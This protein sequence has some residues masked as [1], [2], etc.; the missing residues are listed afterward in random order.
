MDQLYIYNPYITKKRKHDDVIKWIHFPR[1]WPFVRGIHWSPMNSSHKG[2][3]R[4]AWMWSLICAS[5]NGSVNNRE[6]GDLRRHR[7]HYDVTVMKEYGHF[8][9]ACNGNQTTLK[10][11]QCRLLPSYH[12]YSIHVGQFWLQSIFFARPGWKLTMFVG[13]HIHEYM[14]FWCPIFP[15]FD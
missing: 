12:K 7:A 4:W 1:Y 3:W 6:A 13:V 14:S 10:C 2:E 9:D 15:S 8:C 11:G 5:I